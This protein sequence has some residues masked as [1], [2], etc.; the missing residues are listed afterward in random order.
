MIYQSM[1]DLKGIMASRSL[2]RFSYESCVRPHPHIS[3][4]FSVPIIGVDVHQLLFDKGA[5]LPKHRSKKV[6]G[7]VEIQLHALTSTLDGGGWSASRSGRFTL[8]KVLPVP[9]G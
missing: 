5:H 4:I 9:T 2:H 7:E 1:S 6:Y 8:D 3:E